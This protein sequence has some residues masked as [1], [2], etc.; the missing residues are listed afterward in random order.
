MIHALI[1][2]GSSLRS[3][4]LMLATLFV[5]IINGC[6]SQSNLVRG[7]E[8]LEKDKYDRAIKELEEAANEKGDVNYYIDT[9]SSLGDAYAKSGQVNNAIAIYRNALQI[10]QLKLREISA[11]RIDIRRELNSKSKVKVQG[12]QDE[13][14]RLGNEE[15]RLKGRAE[16]IKNKLEGL[17]EKQ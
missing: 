1:Y 5:L 7:K 13:D 8:Y 2:K 12:R 6:A 3:L 15:W 14:M 10:I 4:C 9:Y 11:R 17:V 16:G